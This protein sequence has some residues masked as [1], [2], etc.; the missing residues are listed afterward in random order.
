M[1]SSEL[2][3]TPLLGYPLPGFLDDDLPNSARPPEHQIRDRPL[4]AGPQMLNPR[5]GRPR[6]DYASSGVC[7]GEARA[8]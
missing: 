6:F 4:S 3:V 7:A 5:A 1:T 2:L 8:R